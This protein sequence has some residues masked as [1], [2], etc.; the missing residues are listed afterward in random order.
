MSLPLVDFRGKI[1]HQTDAVLQALQQATGRER[2]EI[3]R[4]VLDEWAAA[5]VHEASLIDR[6]LKREG[7]RGIAGGLAGSQRESQGASGSVRDSGGA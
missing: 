2:S 6:H 3:V 1:T 5:K 7:L 4:D